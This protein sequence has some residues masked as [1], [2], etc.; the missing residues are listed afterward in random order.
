MFF[1]IT[2]RRHCNHL[3]DSIPLFIKGIPLQVDLR[4]PDLKID[5]NDGNRNEV[6]MK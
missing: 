5:F 6:K 1:A 2:I 4:D 3:L